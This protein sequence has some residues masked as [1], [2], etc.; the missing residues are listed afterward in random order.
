MQQGL[1]PPATSEPKNNPKYMMIDAQLTTEIFG[2]LA[3]V[4]SDIALKIAYLPIRVSAKYDA[5]WISQFYITMHSLAS[6][7]DKSLTIQQQTLW[8][9][10][11]ARL[12]LPK[13]STPAKMY[14]FIINSYQSNPDKNNWEKTRDQ[15]YQRYQVNSADGYVYKDPFEAGINFAASLVS[16]FY[17]EGDIVRTIQIGSLA[18]W[19]SDNP[20]ATWGGLLG[21]IIGKQGVEQAFKQDNLSESYWIHRTRRNFPDHTPNQL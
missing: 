1:L 20:T 19:D 11:Q 17:G 5:Q 16:L 13:Q 7:V 14:D 3:P 4:R 18:G 9:A 12:I 21:F 2:L 15:V 6:K 8:L 10:E